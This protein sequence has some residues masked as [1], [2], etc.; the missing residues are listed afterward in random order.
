MSLIGS[1]AIFCF[2][3]CIESTTALKILFII[4]ANCNMK[5]MIVLENL[6]H[7]N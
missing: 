3:L 2:V 4:H 1:E 6:V 5:F 7:L